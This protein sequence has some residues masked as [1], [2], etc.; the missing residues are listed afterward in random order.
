MR[1]EKKNTSTEGRYSGTVHTTCQRVN[2]GKFAKR[3]FYFVVVVDILV[4]L[5]CFWQFSINFE[6]ILVVQLE[7]ASLHHLMIGTVFD[8]ENP[9]RS[10]S[11]TLSQSKT[12]SVRFDKVYID[13]Q[14]KKCKIDNVFCWYLAI[15]RL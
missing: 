4:G 15:N 12:V 8:F 2:D 6:C 1:E 10:P 14:N 11:H 3:Q 9:F 7:N 13:E 5:F